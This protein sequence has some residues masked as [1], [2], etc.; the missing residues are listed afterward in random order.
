MIVDCAIYRDGFR[1]SVT[2]DVGSA[3]ASVRDQPGAFLW[4]GLHEPAEGEFD[5]VARELSLHPLAIEDATEGHQRPKIEQH[6]DSFF[7]VIKTV[8][9]TRPTSVTLGEIMLFVGA[10]FVITVRHG[11]ANPLAPARAR[12]EEDRKLLSEGPGAVLYTVLDEVVDTYTVVAHEL[13]S[14]L[15]DLERRIFTRRG[16]DHT[17]DIYTVKREVLE[18]RTA[19]D[20]LLPVMQELVKGRIRLCANLSD[21]FR[22]VQD[23]LL[24]MDQQIDAHNELITNVLTAHLALLGRQQNEDVRKISA[25]AAILALPTMIAGIYGMN[26]QHMPELKWPIGYPLAL[27][28]MIGACLMLYRRFKRGGWL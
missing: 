19:E 26:F 16:G 8:A 10:D 2:G 27:G 21:R 13:E 1:E 22:D 18:F 5:E 28:V 12:L 7:V 4:V 20:P 25:W 3:L 11:P 17:E 15:M 23:H 24:R 9:Y 14:D 6:G